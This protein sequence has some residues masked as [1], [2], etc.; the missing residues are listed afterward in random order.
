LTY[1]DRYFSDQFQGIPENGYTYMIKNML[2]HKNI[3]IELNCDFLSNYFNYKTLVYSGKIDEFF[4]YKYGQLDYRSLRFQ[5]EVINGD[6]QGNSIVNFTDVNVPYTR[7]IEHKHFVYGSQEKSVITKEFP[8]SYNT[9][10][11]PFYPIQDEKNKMIYEKYKMESKEKNLIFGGRLG[12][13]K[14]Y[15]MHQIIAQALSKAKES[16]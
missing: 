4:D 2:D 7:I 5:T 12:T 1:D 10:K 11:V 9:S 3:E 8:D 14:Y 16:L 13:Y 15:D 6:F